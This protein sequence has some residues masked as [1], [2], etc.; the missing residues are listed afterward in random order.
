MIHKKKKS[1]EQNNSVAKPLFLHF[2]IV[3]LLAGVLVCGVAVLCYGT[4]K[5]IGG[6]K[7]AYI[8]LPEKLTK[9]DAAIVPGTAVQDEYLSAKALERLKAAL[10][11]Y[12]NNLA[13]Q[14]I[15]SGTEEET[16]LMACWLL[17]HEVPAKCI[18]AD[19]KGYDTHETV[20]RIAAWQKGKTYWLCS[21]E[22]YADR[23][24]FL[25]KAADMDGEV[26]CADTMYYNGAG[27]QSVREFF[28]ATKAVGEVIFY[29]GEP[30]QE[31]EPED[32]AMQ[33]EVPEE[34]PHA[35]T[36]EEM[37]MP[38]DCI[39]R[40]IAPEDGYDVETAI[41]YAMDH[42][43][44]YNPEYPLFEN[45]CTNFVSQCLVAGGIQMHG[46]SKISKK[47]KY[48]ISRGN[49]KWYSKYM[50]SEK[51]GRRHYATT[52][53]FI[54]TDAFLVYFTE[55]LGYGYSTYDNTY[56]GQSECLKDM[57]SGDVLILYDAEGKVAHIGLITG[58]GQWNAYYC[59]NTNNRRNISVFGVGSEYPEIGI[60]HMSEIE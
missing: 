14:I 12:E 9:K 7:H 20:M 47:R 43:L 3:C 41:A 4:V 16:E 45:N 39:V 33:W 6:N 46:D 44:S 25:M 34:D 36:P 27:K 56:D 22:L 51:T 59:S 35:I 10:Y 53:N 11:L 31:V 13:E 58:I 23:A 8:E 19:S 26:L 15:V 21:Q 2:V 28:A 1:S 30:K 17:M 40:D 50:I 60:L 18:A 49:E 5:I 48:S 24:R 54:N 52:Q 29:R 57:A 37:E 32:F 42:A 55:Q 38:E